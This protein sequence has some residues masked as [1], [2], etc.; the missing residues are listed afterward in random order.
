MS[1]DTQ[2]SYNIDNF[3]QPKTVITESNSKLMLYLED[4]ED[5]C[6][7][8]GDQTCVNRKV[9]TNHFDESWCAVDT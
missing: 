5:A 7:I 4:T 9:K 2:A 8:S 3:T 6:L 1:E